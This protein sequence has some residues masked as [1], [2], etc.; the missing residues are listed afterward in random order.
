MACV[1]SRSRRRPP[2][3]GRPPADPG[4]PPHDPARA[5]TPRPARDA[6]TM[7][8]V[9]HLRNGA[10]AVAETA[11]AALHLAGRLPITA[12]HR[13]DL[14]GRRPRDPVQAA[15]LA[16]RSAGDVRPAAVVR[17][18]AAGSAAVA[19]VAARLVEQGLAMDKARE[20]GVDDA[21]DFEAAAACL[22]GVL[23]IAAVIWSAAADGPWH[24]LRP[25]GAFAL[26]LVVRAGRYAGRDD[27]PRARGA[28]PA[29]RAR[30]EGV[31]TDEAWEPRPDRGT[32]LP[33]GNRRTVAE[34]SRRGLNALTLPEPALAMVGGPRP[35]KEDR[36]A[37]GPRSPS[38]A[39]S[40]AGSAGSAGS[41]NRDRSVC[42][43]PS[44]GA[45][46]AGCGGCGGGFRGS[47]TLF[48]GRIRRGRG[49]SPCCEVS[50]DA[51]TRAY[52]PQYLAR[53]Q[54]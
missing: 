21:T 22:A 38:N 4:P 51:S 53:Y 36:S 27:R 20:K 18:E 39:S 47:R 3:N 45:G 31:L 1:P 37:A 32:R 2:G 13:L 25:L 48:A 33:A 40:S 5:R 14:T 29:G 34:V 41:S 12:D 23:G 11:M 24:W 7:Y 15:V 49:S 44:L 19:R 52:G 17:D 8:E 42:D 9:A 10:S 35:D 54:R 46:C 16:L 28:S 50:S 26:L 30:Y 43:P 6:L